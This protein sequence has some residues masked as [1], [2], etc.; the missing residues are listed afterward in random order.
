MAIGRAKAS[1]PFPSVTFAYA[2]LP[3]LF[4]GISFFRIH[5]I[6]PAIIRALLLGK[7]DK[8]EKGR[9]GVNV[10]SLV[11]ANPDTV[12]DGLADGAVDAL[13]LAQR[14]FR[15]APLGVIAKTNNQATGCAFRLNRGS[16]E[17]YREEGAIFPD[18]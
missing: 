1:F 14:L 17:H 3:G 16:T 12:I 7:T 10:S 4:G 6:S 9:T 5:G 13:T 11:V 18:K 2:F 8:L 15:L